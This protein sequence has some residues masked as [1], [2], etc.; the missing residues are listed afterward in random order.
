MDKK[1][2]PF[3]LA[4]LIDYTLLKPA[5]T[6][7]E[8]QHLCNEAQKYQFYSVC[9]PP[10]FV[11]LA[12]GLLKRSPA[13][14]TT[15]IGFPMGYSTTHIKKLEARNAIARGAD[16]LDIVMNIGFLKEGNDKQVK[17]E[18][19]EIINISS[20]TVFKII[21][22]SSLLT[23]GEKERAVQIAIDSGAD[24][25]KTS[26]GLLGPG[27]SIEDIRTLKGMIKN[28]I[29]LKAAGGI[30]DFYTAEKIVIAGADRIGSSNGV[31]IYKE[32]LDNK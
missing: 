27:V 12:H 7:K 15:V 4:Q 19:K 9:V 26:T 23:G 5:V 32:C 6:T 3:S 29:K 14:V 1:L 22:E 16:E 2:T 24:F 8:I 25:V 13:L 31:K 20:K 18:I 28:K 10:C 17:N 30:K 11:S 21:I